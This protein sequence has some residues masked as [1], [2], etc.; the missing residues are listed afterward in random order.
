MRRYI[1]NYQTIVEFTEPVSVHSII[2]RCQ[3]VNNSCQSVEQEQLVLSPNYWLEEGHDAFS[4]RI[5]YGGSTKPHKAFAY[6]STGIVST[7][8]YEV[9]T[10][11]ENLYLYR[12]PTSLT[13]VYGY[14]LAAPS[15][16][17]QAAHTICQWLHDHISYPPKSTT[18]DTSAAEV[19]ERKQG[20]CQDFAHLMLAMCRQ[21]GIA[22]RYVNGFLVGEGET[23]AWV[24]V[25]DGNNWQ[26]FDPTNNCQI[27][28]GYV[29]LAHG[30][31]AHDCSVCRGMYT[32]QA[33][34][35]TNIHVTLHEI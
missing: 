14:V 17:I 29:K 1:Y 19:L 31:D 32:G 7:E 13:N 27:S 28:E 23:H 22:S 8:T 12:Q 24:E 4:N 21:R 34:Q 25:Y 11:G 15:N 16:E 30:R 35:Q 9:E 10:L 33:R 5:L 20:V 26:G 2:L 18:V 3:P 6:I